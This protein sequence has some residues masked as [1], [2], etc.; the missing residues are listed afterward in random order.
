M[1][2]IRLKQIVETLIGRCCRGGN[3]FRANL[4]RFNTGTICAVRG[5]VAKT[6]ALYPGP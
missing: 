4:R 1:K 2:N 5:E 6:V 3:G